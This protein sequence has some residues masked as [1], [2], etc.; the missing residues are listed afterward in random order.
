M[1]A[2]RAPDEDP[3]DRDLAGALHEVANALTV[4]LGWLETARAQGDSSGDARA[5][6]I[7]YARAR[8]AQAIARRAIGG[9]VPDEE[10]PRPLGAVVREAIVGLEPEARRLGVCIVNAVGKPLELSL[11]PCG[12]R[13]VQI[14]TN[15]LLNAIAVSPRGGEVRVDGSRDH[16]GAL[17]LAVVDEGPGVPTARRSAIF[18]GGHSTRPGGAGVGLRYAHQLART[19]GG[20]LR[21]SDAEGRGARFELSWPVTPTESAPPPTKPL[22]SRGA[23]TGIRILVLEDDDAV[24][25]LL[26]TALTARGATVHAIRRGSEL[27]DALE[28]GP[29]DAALLDLSPIASEVS[30]AVVRVRDQSPDARIVVISGSALSMPPLP[31][32]YRAEWVRKPFEVSEIVAAVLGDGDVR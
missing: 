11:L 7:A 25:D 21:L 3:G 31:E 15:L 20:A 6:D 27:D 30:D 13:V 10:L 17:V 5:V 18:A 14:L 28:S 24:I 4:V 29:F 12:D 2:S 1:A 19:H 26:D 16:D 23:L 22:S 8:Q 9:E 32:G